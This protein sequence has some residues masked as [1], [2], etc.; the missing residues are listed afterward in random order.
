MPVQFF[1]DPVMLCHQTE[2]SPHIPGAA[3]VLLE[4]VMEEENSIQS[5][6]ALSKL[7]VQWSFFYSE[8]AQTSFS[9]AL[10]LPPKCFSRVAAP[11][12]PLPVK[13]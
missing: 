13:Y 9:L 12:Q 2:L 5:C 8:T 4:K 7:A 3:V 10:A 6:S 1:E 11:E